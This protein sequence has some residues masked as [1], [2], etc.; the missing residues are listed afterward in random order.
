MSEKWFCGYMHRLD[1]EAVQEPLVEGVKYKCPCCGAM[2]L[3]ERG[4]YDICVW[5]F[6]EDDGQDDPHAAE[7]WGGPNGRLSL[8][9]AREN[10]KKFG[11]CEELMI[12][13]VRRPSE[14]EEAYQKRMRVSREEYAKS[15]Q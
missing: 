5:C 4:G 3:D 2:S 9:A 10:F 14:T 1:N 12:D 7:I 15:K 8:A 11:A 13:T 6:W